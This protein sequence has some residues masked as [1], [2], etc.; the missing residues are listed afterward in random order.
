M[1]QNKKTPKETSPIVILRQNCF[2]WTKKR[3]FLGFFENTPPP[4]CITST[5]KTIQKSIFA[6]KHGQ[7]E[8]QKPSP[9]C[10]PPTMELSSLAKV[11]FLGVRF[12][13]KC[14]QGGY[15]GLFLVKRANAGFFPKE[16]NDNSKKSAKKHPLF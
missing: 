4:P 14:L 10:T 11:H 15:L 8:R 16:I 12:L 13:K 9:D 7:N 1:R 2:L 5:P 3:P 6:R